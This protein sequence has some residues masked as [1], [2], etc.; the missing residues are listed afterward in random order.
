MVA[1][2]KL[3]DGQGETELKGWTLVRVRRARDICMPS[4]F[5]L[6]DI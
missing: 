4:P 3:M 5:N 1:R 6:Q 2:D